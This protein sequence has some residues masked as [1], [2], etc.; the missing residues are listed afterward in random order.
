MQVF[1]YIDLATTGDILIQNGDFVIGEST[2]Q[3]MQDLLIADKGQY[4]LHPEVGVG[5]DQFINADFYADEIAAAIQ[6]DYTYDGLRISK[7]IVHSGQDVS[8]NASYNE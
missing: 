4:R 5:I 2:A 3:H 1:D 6:D 7:L 8:I